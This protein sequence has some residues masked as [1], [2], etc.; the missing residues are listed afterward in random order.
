MTNRIIILLL[1]FLLFACSVKTPE[2]P[3]EKI[4]VNI[5]NIA[6]ISVNEFLRRAEYVPRPDYCRANTYL[7]KKII[8]NSLIAEKLLA[9]EA[10]KNSPLFSNK[11]FQYFIKGHK[12]QAM[13]QYMHHV[14]ATDKVVLEATEINNAYKVAGRNYD[15]AYFTLDDSLKVKD[16]QNKLATNPQMFQ[17]VYFQIAGDTSVPH[18]KVDWKSNEQLKVHQALFSEDLEKGQVLQPMKVD[19]NK[20]LFIKILG[21]S[22]DL[23]ITGKQ[24]QERLKVVTEKLTQIKAGGIWDKRVAQIM[25][26]KHMDFN[27]E[28]FYMLTELL[29]DTYFPSSEKKHNSAIN[30]LWKKGDEIAI[31]SIHDLNDEGLL[32]QSFFSVDGIVW[33]IEDFRTQLMSHPLVFRNQHMKSKEFPRQFR[34]AVA[35]FIRDYYVTEKAYEAKYDNVNLV[36][37][38]VN[39]WE[40][41]FLAL[42]KK[43]EYL[44]S[45]GET[46]SFPENYHKILKETLNPY[47]DELQQKYYKKI[48]LDFD[49]FEDIVLTKIDLFVK[50]EEQPF[51]SVV[52]LFPIITDDNLIEYV[53]KMNSNINKSK[54]GEN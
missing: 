8:L 5:A 37:R 14:E 46:R 15:I 20:Y 28:I 52:P 9:I 24:Q 18:R 44:K 17:D 31:K 48:E 4:L 19:K 32:Q 3:Q 13:R 33:T 43:H 11:E 54:G 26:G 50:Y 22:D 21:W 12:E 34:L 42:T 30:Q 7:H 23:L 39:M 51:N 38:N 53:T 16:A 10:G 1:S 36:K 29:Y 25:R 2:D 41:T 47:I 27:E 6:T 49:A 45:V 35:D 40:D